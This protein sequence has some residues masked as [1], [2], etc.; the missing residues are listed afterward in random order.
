MRALLIAAVFSA[1]GFSQ[2]PDVLLWGS[3]EPGPYTAGYRAYFEFDARRVYGTPRGQRP[4][5]V[6]LWYPAAEP[7][8]EPVRYRE[9]ITP[10][11]LTGYSDFRSRLETF[12]LDAVS[13][14]IFQKKRAGLA[15]AELAFLDSLL[16]HP[17]RAY[18]D[19]APAAGR[20][21]IILYHPGAAGSYE[22][23]S[24]LCEYLAS[25][26]YVVLTSAFQSRDAKYVSNNY[27]GPDTSWADMAFLL[28]HARS[29]PFADLLNAGAIG[30]SMGAQYL[31]EWLGH[32]HPPL[33]AVI[34][35]DTTLERA[36]PH[37]GH[38]AL[39]KGIAHLAPQHVPALLMAPADYR[40]DFSPWDGYLPCRV[41][42]AP[43]YFEHNDFLLHGSLART[44]NGNRAAEVRQNYDQLARVVRAFFDA[45]LKGQSGGWQRLLE[46][47]RPEFRV[48]QRFCGGPA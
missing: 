25:Y 1:I 39:R 14:D 46:E 8:G 41:E 34:S 11:A 35:L 27:G 10:P 7:K 22:D 44:F 30:H 26:G 13:G 38:A 36:T 45:N 33:G 17:T 2:A 48:A 12:L 3:L 42:A 19:A 32:R 29:L 4:I 21:P 16:S 24:A 37:P 5:L 43:A 47:R 31:L 6:N 15:P 20:F 23:N 9:Y 40:P 18:R 28:T